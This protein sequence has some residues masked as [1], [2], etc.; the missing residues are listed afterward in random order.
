MGIEEDAPDMDGRAKTGMRHMAGL[1]VG[2]QRLGTTDWGCG[3]DGSTSGK[4]QDGVPYGSFT[5]V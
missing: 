2:A 4:P 1:T 5:G 3:T